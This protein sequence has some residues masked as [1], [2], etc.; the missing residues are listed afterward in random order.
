MHLIKQYEKVMF[1]ILFFFFVA[2]VNASGINEYRT[3]SIFYSA[4]KKKA[5]VFLIPLL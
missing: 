2:C 3:I 4:Y 1:K 5:S